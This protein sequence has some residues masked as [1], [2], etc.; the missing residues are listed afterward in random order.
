MITLPAGITSLDPMPYGYRRWNNTVWC[1]IH[2]DVY[3]RELSRI[4]ERHAAGYDTT[5][6][7]SGLYNLAWQFDTLGA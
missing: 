4:A 1:D 2:V 7:V 5:A 6:L 3:N